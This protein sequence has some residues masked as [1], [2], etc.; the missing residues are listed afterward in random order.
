MDGGNLAEEENKYEYD[1]GY[2]DPDD[3]GGSGYIYGQERYMHVQDFFSI[4]SG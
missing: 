1:L 4:F 2:G 3:D